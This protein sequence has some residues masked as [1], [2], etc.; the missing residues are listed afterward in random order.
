MK[1]T[2]SYVSAGA[3]GASSEVEGSQRR[4]AQRSQV[5]VLTAGVL[6]VIAAIVAVLCTELIGTLSGPGQR[7]KQKRNKTHH[8]A[9]HFAEPRIFP[10]TP[11]YSPPG[12]LPPRRQST[13]FNWFSA[14]PP[15]VV[16]PA[17]RHER[18]SNIWNQ[19]Q[20]IGTNLLLK[21]P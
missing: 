5:S 8:Q 9:I 2:A 19:E 14:S 11:P 3:R 18:P 1:R 15:V 6:V 20:L 10:P 17:A 16:E 4:Q 13:P 21:L 7:H 12:Y